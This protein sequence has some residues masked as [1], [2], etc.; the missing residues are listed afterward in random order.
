MAKYIEADRL[1]AEIKFAKSVYDNPKRVVNGVADAYRQDGRAAMCDDILKRIDS[2]Q[3][4]E[5]QVDKMLCSQVWWEE[6]GWIMIPP[7]ATIEGIDSLLRQVRKKFQQ[8]STS[9]TDA[10][11][12]E[13]INLLKKYRIG[14]ET[15][16]T[17]A[18]RIADT[19]GVQRYMDGLCDGSNKEDTKKE[20]PEVDL[21]KEIEKEWKECDPIDEGMGVESAYIHIEAFDII[22][23]RFFELGKKDM[24]KQM[25][26]ESVKAN[27]IATKRDNKYQQLLITDWN[28]FNDLLNADKVRII[29]VKE[30]ENK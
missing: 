11:H 10:L 9:D 16:R 29:I 2:L 26:K 28:G 14:E 18:D 30:E 12:T 27:V 19:Y 7:D 21:E 20:Q 17:I 22:A 5:T 8:E 13:L 24:K 23:H 1:R 6:Q 15:A 25:M 3:Q 4:D